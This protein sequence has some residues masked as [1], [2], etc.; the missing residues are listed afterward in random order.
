MN[1]KRLTV[2]SQ[3]ESL[4]TVLYVSVLEQNCLLFYIETKTELPMAYYNISDYKWLCLVILLVN[5][6]HVTVF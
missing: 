6:K 3:F 2:Q 5:L 4:S 1:T